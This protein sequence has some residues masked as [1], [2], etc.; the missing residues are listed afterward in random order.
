MNLIKKEKINAAIKDRFEYSFNIP[1]NSVY[2]IEIIASARSWKQNL[3]KIW[4]DPIKRFWSLFKDDDLVVELDGISFPGVNK[5]GLLDI[6]LRWNENEAGEAVW[7]GNNLKGLDKTNLIIAYL[8]K[9]KHTLIFS[10]NQAPFLKKIAIYKTG[11]E[12][13]N[14]VPEEN[15]PPEDGDKR[16]W[17]TAVLLDLSLEKLEINGTADKKGLDDG[18]IKLIIDGATVL[19]TE[20][21]SH[22]YWYW[23]GRTLL[24]REKQYSKELNL[25]KGVHYIELWS[26]KTPRIGDISIIVG[27]AGEKITGNKSPEHIIG[28]IENL[29][30]EIGQEIKFNKIPAPIESFIK[31][32]K[33]IGIASKEFGVDPA[34][35]KAT[36]SQESSF[37]KIVDHDSRYV[38]ESGLMG[39]EKKNSIAQLA[40]LGYT[41]N[42]NDIEDVIR[43]SAAYYK[44]LVGF[45]VEKF[46][47]S[48]NPLKLYTQYSKDLEAE[49]T[50]A[51]GIKEFLYYYFYYL[52]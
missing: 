30:R 49:N 2:A 44:W 45:E 1:K 17:I 26:D 48:R 25:G 46:E 22:K 41:F 33:E 19:N 28:K 51:P 20:L 43:A 40:K 24:G 16:Q 5:E 38:G 18:D 6:L 32:D 12:K 39:L 36:I 47:D 50:K 27:G 35:L 11:D 8:S 29:Y 21:K 3:I 4:Q 15:N 42:Y 10:V 31:Y 13:I 9:G 14:F 7:N 23:C 52:Q 37:G 34:I